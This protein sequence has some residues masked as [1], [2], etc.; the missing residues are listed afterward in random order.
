MQST[1]PDK[2]ILR[3]FD[4]AK[5]LLLSKKKNVFL[6]TIFFSLKKVWTLDIPTAATDGKTIWLNPEFFKNIGSRE[7]QIF[8]LAHETWHVALKHMIRASSIPDHLKRLANIAMDHVINLMLKQQ[9]FLVWEHALCNSK[10]ENMSFEAVFNELLK[11]IQENDQPN[12]MGEDVVPSSSLPK[13]IEEK[14]G[15]ELDKIIIRAAIQHKELCGDYGDLPGN[16]RTTLESLLNPTIPWNVAFGQFMLNMI[17]NSRSYKRPRRGQQDFILPS[18]VKDKIEKVMIFFDV[19]GSITD[20]M[21][22]KFYTELVYLQQSVEIECIEIIGF[23]IGIT[24]RFQFDKAKQTS[25][26]LQTGGGTN[27]KPVMKI[28]QYEEP[29]IAVIFTDGEFEQPASTYSKNLLWIISG[30]EYRPPF[31]QVIYMK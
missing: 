31:G 19:S 10:F 28:L 25:L 30:S 6:N 21:L 1:S 16:I 27:I 8:I 23:N 14:L 7:L 9:G 11:N 26:N 29:N 24:E 17:K 20:E 3:Q 13:D 5:F 2:E 22:T 4:A 15:A 18:Q 12:A